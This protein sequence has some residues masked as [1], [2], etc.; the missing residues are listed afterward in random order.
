MGLTRIAIH[1]PIAI[2]ML[3][4]AFLTIGL[5]GYFQLPAELNPD[6][7]FPTISI[8]TQYAGTDPQEMETLITKPIEDSIAG[9]SGI[10]E[11]DST[12]EQGQSLV[13]IQFYFG[14]DL[15]TA[16]AQ[17]IQKVDAI[18]SRLPVAASSPSVRQA[19]TNGQPV[20]GIAMQSD[21]YSQQ[22]L[23][24][25]AT[26][27]VQPALEQA[28]DVGE[29]DVSSVTTREI[30]VDLDPNRLA[31]YGVSVPDI[32]N[33]IGGANINV[34]SGFIETGPQ[35][36][37]VRLIGEFASVDEIRAL[38]LT[39]GSS[40][41]SSGGGG[42]TQGSAGNTSSAVVNQADLGGGATSS[43]STGSKTFYLS[44]VANVYDTTAQP[45]SA[46]FL[47]G[48]PAVQITVLKTTDGNTLNAIK[49]CKEELK[50]IAIDLPANIHFTISNDQSVQVSSNLADV[51]TSLF[52][53]AILAILVVYAFLHN[54]R[55]TLIVAIAIPTSMIATFVPLW[56][57][58]F[59]LNSYSLLGLSLAVGI[60]VDDSIVVLENINRHLQLG[61]EPIVAAINGRTEIGLAAIVLTSVN[62][63][64][65]LPIAFMGG[66]TGLLYRSFGITV[67]FATL[68][69]LFVSFT[70]TPMLAARWYRK[71]ESL[72]F[73]WQVR[74]S[75]R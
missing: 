31:A 27:I 4:A 67:A 13:R 40:G 57:L 60:L 17:V 54:A 50:A 37:D 7:E 8:S 43:G 68:F 45:T 34:A 65:F 32:V 51:V 46:S 38:R 35:Y 59:T 24:T 64:V 42:A 12:S 49:S 52:L 28:T 5:I 10:E 14:T 23:Q 72:E 21:Q 53:G 18:R 30:H 71:G 26:N 63:V 55:G 66:L 39:V 16:D 36:Y 75:L 41:G 9:V 15:D 74:C 20:L 6:I 56:A 69:S 47:D 33:A 1:R 44:D 11:I 2:L 70:L 73:D 3:V 58:G 19:N 62:L 29:V 25:M 22:Q 61:E 48:K